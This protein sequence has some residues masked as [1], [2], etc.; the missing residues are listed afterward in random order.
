M[1][2]AALLWIACSNVANLL[3]A[4][5]VGRRREI[6]IRLATGA[7]RRRIVL[8]LLG[9]T[10]L[11]ALAGGALGVLVGAWTLDVVF[12]TFSQFGSIDVSLDASVLAYTAAVSCLAT[13]LAGLVP[14]LE[15]SRGDV[16]SVLK[17]EGTSLTVSVRGARLRAVFLTVQ[18]AFALALLMVAGTFVRAPGR[19]AFRGR[20]GPL[21]SRRA[22]AG[23]PRSGAGG[24][25]RRDL[26]RDPRRA[27]AHAWRPRRHGAQ[28]GRDDGAGAHRDRRPPRAG[29]AA[30][31][32]G[33]RRR[34]PADRRRADRARPRR[35]RGG[36]ASAAASAVEAPFEAVVNTAAARRI[37]RQG[38]AVSQA[39]DRTLTLG[40][41]S[42]RV[43][44]VVEDGFTE[45][46]VYRRAAATTNASAV[47]FLVR[48]EAPAAEALAALRSTLAAQLPREARPMVGTWRDA[49]LR[50]LG[51]IS[52]VGAL[53]G[54]LAL[55]L[56][57]AG[58]AGSMAFHGRQRARGIAVRR[59]LGA[60]TSA[61]LRLVAAQA[62]RI[63]GIGL[64]L[65]LALGWLGTH[66]L[67]SLMGAPCLADRLDRDRRRGRDLRGD[68]RPRPP[69]GRPGARSASSRRRCST[70]TSGNPGPLCGVQMEQPLQWRF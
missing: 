48:T 34:L 29:G 50:G 32:A 21:R 62:A 28:R 10:L 24:H 6:A 16:S 55:L 23:E 64:A 39:V 4:R 19:V 13:V 47:T 49:N 59:A 65:G 43:V 15:A 53:L 46:R 3:L 20:R 41:S 61:V 22:G 51:G 14:A 27:G 37:A 35:D 67:L 68:D 5:G 57:G 30:D 45:A 38:E 44:G 7:S 26:G 11:L 8:L 18:V 42:A 25:A 69:S 56:A 17:A 40:G 66:A 54:L 1:I 36:A 70:R 9:E 33:D 12:A 31:G 52:R 2:V 63:T 60:N 58:V